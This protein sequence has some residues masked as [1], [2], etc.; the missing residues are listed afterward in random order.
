VKAYIIRVSQPRLSPL[1]RRLAGGFLALVGLSLFHFA[2]LRTDPPETIHFQPTPEQQEFY[3]V[4]FDAQQA[5]YEQ[6]ARLNAT[7]AH[8]RER[9]GAFVADN[10][11]ERGHVLEIG[12]GAGLLQ[13]V[14]EDYTGLDISATARS[15][16]HKRFVQADARAMPFGDGEFDAAWSIWVL[17]HIPN[18]EQALR[19]MRRVLKP[20]GLLFLEPAWYCSDLAPNGYEVRPYSDFGL[21]GKAI[22]ATARL[23]GAPEFLAFHMLPVRAVRMSAWKLHGQP[24]ALRYRP[25][26]PNYQTYW[27]AD[28]DAVNSIDMYEAYLWFRS[29]GDE[30][31]NCRSAADL[32]QTREQPLIIRVKPRAQTD[33]PP[34]QTAASIN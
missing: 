21:A 32:F 16:Y 4:A 11:L 19:E 31:L 12:S 7:S 6:I 8:V 30:C 25:I 18:P 17:E 27:M 20:N 28:S 15:K 33:M 23:Q 24:T 1:S 26:T 3:N 9:I 34:A 10:H 14:V 22:K 2:P 29:R 13:D 5:R